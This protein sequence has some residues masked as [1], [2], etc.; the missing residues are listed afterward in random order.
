MQGLLSITQASELLGLRPST[1]Y[2]MVCK[3]TI[4]FVKLGSRVLFA[5]ESLA[6]WVEER[7]HE[8]AAPKPRR[9]QRAI[10]VGR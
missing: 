6:R 7:S 1:L 10:K 3:R 9:Q 2:K 5:P 4:N 8:P